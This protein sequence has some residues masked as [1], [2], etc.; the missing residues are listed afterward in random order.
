MK[1][2]RRVACC[3][4]CDQRAALM[5]CMLL[6][7]LAAIGCSDNNSQQI[8]GQQFVQPEAGSVLRE[9]DRSPQIL[10]VR[11]VS[12]QCLSNQI[13]HAVD[14][15][16]Q[17]LTQ[18]GMTVE[19]S[20]AID[21]D[22]D[23]NIVL[24]IVGHGGGFEEQLKNYQLSVAEK[25]ESLLIA[26][27]ETDSKP[28]IVI[29]GSDRRGLAYGVWEAS[30]A[31]RLSPPKSDPL[32]AIKEAQETPH[33]RVRSVTTQLFN[34]DVE[35]AW[36]E[37]EEYWHWF[38]GMLARNRFNNYS[39]TF[40]HNSNYMIPP[41]AWMFEVPEYPDV[42]VAGISDAE[43]EQNLHAFRRIGEI[44]QEY[45]VEFTIGLW[46]QLPV[47][48]VRVGLDYGESPVVNLPPGIQGGDY[49]AEGLR[50]LL[51]LCPAISGVQLRMNLE[52]GIPHEEQENYY[53]AQ[54]QAIADCGRRVKLDLR[55]KSLSQETIDLAVDAG[56]DVNVS[57]KYWCEHMGLPFHPTWQDVA[58][59]ESRYG[60]GAMLHRPRNYSVTYRLWN[61]GTSRLLLWGDP[62]YASRFA[63]SCTLGG[64]QGFEIFA[65][66]ANKGYGNQPGAWR[67]FADESQEHFRWEYE[68]YWPFFLSFGRFGYNPNA[69]HDI[70]ERE[71]AARFGEAA[72]SFIKAF[73]S[74]SQILPL[75]TA[76][77]QFS[78]NNWRFWPEMV[79]CMHLDAY[80]AIQPS[81]YSQFYAIAPFDSRQHWRG[82]GWGSKHSAFV[83]DA[84]AGN[85][86]S[87]WTPIEVSNRLIEP[88]QIINDAYCE[89]Y[90]LIDR[91][92]PYHKE[93][94]AIF[95]DLKVLGN[96]GCYH[97]FK[98][99]AAVHLE[100]FRLTKDK[101]RLPLVWK[102]INYA[103]GRWDAI[104]LITDGIYND[105]MVFGFSREHNSD[106]PDRLQEH[107]GHWTDRNPEIEADIAFVAELLKK[108]GIEPTEHVG[109]IEDT[110][111]RYPG[112]T[113]LEQKPVITHKRIES[114]QPDDELKIVAHVESKEALRDVSVYY[115]PTD[116]TRPWK[117]K[118]LSLTDAGSYEGAI[119]AGEVD[120]QFDFQYYLEARVAHGG[121]FWP[122]W[123]KE[124]PYV[125]VL[126]GK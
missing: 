20:Q 81:D 102:Y 80:R 87:K 4:V 70:W 88:R 72:P 91:K 113:P 41:Y 12:N 52:S 99:L 104:E 118:A 126:T 28:T 100:F 36:Y 49:C 17:N 18:R 108:N 22:A 74:A 75:I 31:V 95:T 111:K 33:L 13:Q 44:A 105:K 84:I 32:A 71:F 48:K 66:L 121:T 101:D 2:I 78:A 50:K 24:G 114:V 85:L 39:L 15:L 5:L 47:V 3:A 76:T 90:R 86:N 63:R 83:E 9:N 6:G 60:Y 59:S 73:Q 125:V 116:Q 46:T 56:L 38:F 64:G 69:S 40:G 120:P 11:L 107:V 77:T 29:A 110:V 45:G 65:P 97:A 30:E 27:P 62:S 53:K 123:Q 119:P 94:Q 26:K 55:Y 57:T 34:K 42:R 79:T 14:Q 96:L 23:V 51:E 115:R 117:R 82:E 92:H 89:A 68:R 7:L 8:S 25:P 10:D 19:K 112:E 16:T 1:P 124:T 37:S 21:A 61:V 103:A 58:Y 54:F 43:R 98:K 109:S 106:F 35:R 93:Y 122:D 67:I